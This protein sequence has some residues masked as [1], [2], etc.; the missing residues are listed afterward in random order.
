MR[1][2]ARVVYVME[3]MRNGTQWGTALEEDE[4]DRR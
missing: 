1:T 2:D 4:H 3:H